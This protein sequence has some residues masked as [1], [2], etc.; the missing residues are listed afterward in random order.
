M[1]GAKIIFVKVW[2]TMSVVILRNFRHDVPLLTLRLDDDGT[3]HAI[4]GGRRSS[5]A[6]RSKGAESDVCVV[7][8]ACSMSA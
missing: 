1:K 4:G 8:Q 5:T 7:R 3:A 2:L 6:S